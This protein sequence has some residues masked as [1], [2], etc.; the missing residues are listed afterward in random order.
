MSRHLQQHLWTTR[1]MTQLT[2]YRGHTR[3]RSSRHQ[4]TMRGEA[5]THRSLTSAQSRAMLGNRPGDMLSHLAMPS[6]TESVPDPPLQ[7]W[8]LMTHNAGWNVL[9]LVIPP[10]I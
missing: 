4:I 1:L 8:S 6:E 10:G 7:T 9:S 5:E 3:L 2:G